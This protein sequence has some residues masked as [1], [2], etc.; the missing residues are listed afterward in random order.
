MII[1]YEV[2]LKMTLSRATQAQLRPNSRVS[3]MLM[4]SDE[5]SS[6]DREE[7]Y[8]NKNEFTDPR[9]VSGAE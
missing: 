3:P 1:P 4:R 2:S 8:L 7:E 6:N 9:K 5:D